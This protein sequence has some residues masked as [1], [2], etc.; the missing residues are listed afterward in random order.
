[1]KVWHI[2]D[3][4]MHHNHL[5]VP[6]EIDIVIHSGDATNFRDPYR[7]DVEM[8]SFLEWYAG[9][10]IK[11]KI[12]VAGNHDTSIEKGLTKKEYIEDLGIK[13]IYMDTI[14]VAGYKVWGSPYCPRYGDWAFM[15][16]RSKMMKKVWDF[17]D[18]SAD[19]IVTHTPPYGFLDLTD[20]Y[21][22]DSNGITRTRILEHAGCKS[23]FKKIKESS[24]KLHCFGHIHNT[25]DVWNAGTFK[26]T[27]MNVL[28]SQASCC[29]DSCSKRMRYN[30]NIID[31]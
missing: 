3:T 22:S 17:M 16:D 31:L 1:M 14:E 11:N 28:F 6:D 27:N 29:R 23:L 18:L 8:K 15:K 25:K 13:Y 7:N 24:A 9:L 10:D 30:G 20:R 2:S 26:P 12:F 4:H 5:V 19:I 21:I